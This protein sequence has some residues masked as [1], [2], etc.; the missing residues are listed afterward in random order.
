MTTITK[1]LN[2]IDEYVGALEGQIE[3]QK[4]LI[5]T[6]KKVDE[7]L[8]AD[9]VQLLDRI[10]ELD[11]T[12][13]HWQDLWQREHDAFTQV[14][15]ERDQARH[16]ASDERRRGNNLKHQL[17]EMTQQRDNW[18]RRAKVL[19]ERCEDLQ[20]GL[21]PETHEARGDTIEYM[22]A[23]ID[24]ICEMVACDCDVSDLAEECIL[25][26][27]GEWTPTD[28]SQSIE[29]LV[30]GI[31][32]SD[33]DSFFGGE[34]IEDMKAE[35]QRPSDPYKYK[36]LVVEEKGDE[37]IFT[38]FYANYDLARESVDL[39]VARG[40]YEAWVEELL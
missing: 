5:K 20:A 31:I 38:G 7:S 14:A 35:D 29:D 27:R 24:N 34:T 11:G 23:F 15:E 6:Y 21:S 16:K 2:A 28:E 33:P 32:D 1:S 4:Q 30:G 40:C 3:T 17:K 26:R 39:M 36:V 12:V 25:W 9:Q 8:Q 13:E 19:E 10:E 37:A 22:T 18:Q